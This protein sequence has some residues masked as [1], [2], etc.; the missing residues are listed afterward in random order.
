F[1]APLPK[2][3]PMSAYRYLNA[4]RQTIVDSARQAPLI[5]MQDKNLRHLTSIGQEMSCRFE[6]IASDTGEAGVVIRGGD[7]LGQFVRSAV[8][9]EEDLHLS[10]DPFRTNPNWR[11][12]WGG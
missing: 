4:R 3:D 2:T 5:R 12:R 6:E 11:T 9:I 8:R 7:Y 1:G 10:I